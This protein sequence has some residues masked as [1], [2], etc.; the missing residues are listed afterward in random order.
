[1]KVVFRYDWHYVSIGSDNGLAPNRQEIIIWTNDQGSPYKQSTAVG[2]RCHF[3]HHRHDKVAI[4]PQLSQWFPHLQYLV[5]TVKIP[6]KQLSL[7]ISLLLHRSK[8]ASASGSASIS[9]DTSTT[10]RP[11][12][13]GCWRLPSRHTAKPLH[14][15]TGFPD[16]KNDFPVIKSLWY[17]S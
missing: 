12:S 7:Q 15:K 4:V 2:H 17:S 9:S 5:I 3:H 11:G 10:G 8:L 14:W 16:V 1:M 13:P 6:I